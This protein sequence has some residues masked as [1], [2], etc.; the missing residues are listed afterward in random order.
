MSVD[1]LR[2]TI[3]GIRLTMRPGL[4]LR[5]TLIAV[6][7]ADMIDV[8]LC[9]PA[10]HIT[11][12]PI[13]TS[14]APIKTSTRTPITSTQGSL[15]STHGSLVS[16]LASTEA[17]LVSTLASTQGS[18]AST[19]ASLTSTQSSLASTLASTQGSLTST[20]GSLTSTQGSLASPQSLLTSTQSSLASTQSSLAS[21]QGSPASTQ[22]SLA[23]TLASTQGTLASTQSSLTPTRSPLAST[24]SS[25][26]STQG[27]I[28]STLA[29][30]Q[31]S[32]TPTQSPLASTE[33]TQRPPTAPYTEAASTLSPETPIPST[34]HHIP[35]TSNPQE[36]QTPTTTHRSPLPSFLPSS[37]RQLPVIEE[38]AGFGD[39]TQAMMQLSTTQPHEEMS[40]E[41]SYR[42]EESN[43]LLK[44]DGSSKVTTPSIIQTLTTVSSSGRAFATLP[45]TLLSS[46]A[47]LATLP[48]MS[49]FT[50]LSPTLPSAEPS[51]TGVPTGV[52]T[53]PPNTPPQRYALYPR[54]LAGDPTTYSL[55]ESPD[56]ELPFATLLPQA[57]TLPSVEEE[58]KQTDIPPDKLHPSTL[59][60]TDMTTPPHAAQKQ[61]ST[62]LPAI[63]V[64]TLLEESPVALSQTEASVATAAPLQTHP[65]GAS[66]TRVT[67]SSTTPATPSYTETPTVPVL[68]TSSAPSTPPYTE[69]PTAPDAP[70]ITQPTLTP[71]QVSTSIPQEDFPTQPTPTVNA[72]HAEEL[73]EKYGY[74]DCIPPGSE[75]NTRLHR[76]LLYRREDPE[77][78]NGHRYTPLDF[79]L[80]SLVNPRLPTD[81]K[82]YYRKKINDYVLSSPQDVGERTPLV[83]LK[84]IEP[85]LKSYWYSRRKGLQQIL[86][87]RGRGA[88]RAVVV[89][90]PAK[91]GYQYLPVCSK[92]QIQGA[93]D[94][95]QAAYHVG[96][97]GTLDPPTLE[98]LSRP[99]CGNPD[100][101]ME[102]DSEDVESSPVWPPNIVSFLHRR[103]RSLVVPER[104]KTDGGTD[105]QARHKD[106]TFDDQNSMVGKPLGGTANQ[107]DPSTEPVPDQKRLQRVALTLREAARAKHPSVVQ[108][109]EWEPHPQEAPLRRRRWVQDLVDRIHS[110]EEDARLAALTPHILAHSSQ[111]PNKE[112]PQLSR[113][114]RSAFTHLGQQFIQDMITWRL[115]T[116]G[117]SSQLAVSVQ[118]AALALAF[119]MWSEVIPKIFIEDNISN[120]INDVNINIGFGR[121]SHL[122]C[123]TEFDGLGGELSHA[124][125]DARD[126]Q[127]H[128][129]DDEHFTLDS[130]HGTNLLKV[131]VHEIGHVLGLGHV[132]RNYSIM[133]AVYEKVLP[134]QGLE[135][136]WEDRKLVQKIYGRCVG[137]FS[138]VFDFLR[139]RP[140][141]SLFYNTFFF[142]SNHFWMYENKY[143]RTRFGDP[144]YIDT[145]W[146][147]LPDDV[148]AYTHI[149][150]NTRDTHLFFKGQT[151]PRCASLFM[152]DICSLFGLFLGRRRMG[153]QLPLQTSMPN[154]TLRAVL[155]S[156]KRAIAV[157]LEF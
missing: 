56:D 50:T 99:R 95:F 126:A 74:L 35:S 111:A 141:G 62:M 17:S 86:T 27:S 115:V 15:E 128:M 120:N 69:S 63:P 89:E 78:T 60:P 21:T 130:D 44:T 18:S 52:P 79:R 58:T 156:D 90:D 13:L 113:R 31:G 151:S 45:F 138:T 53:E 124:L 34:S 3:T 135:L 61:T 46:V 147:G 70:L 98:L 48:T 12:Q 40:T 28:A 71:L 85:T 97:G 103:R 152:G 57:T 154:L 122:G 20:Q 116:T 129:D 127:I 36:A 131:A 112:E 1:N 77:P 149:F 25:L 93:I 51:T 109:E 76:L 55:P 41:T 2:D 142:R 87:G 106:S 91:L 133:Y 137:K 88:R 84:I 144:L 23:S 140:D 107:Y 5:L 148:D 11:H 33:H 8:A 14:P 157:V 67:P 81:M 119:R 64:T 30:T 24:Q 59:P 73:L 125:R 29:P 4:V 38:R 68:K 134:N 37:L 82:Q 75:R 96:V 117:Y 155:K 146:Q 65:T 16:T 42:A 139:W 105:E 121:R 47:G 10:N 54:L 153:V 101:L 102:E 110:G 108:H 19:Q 145:E 104:G 7:L 43:V 132:L 143:N 80:F 9:S 114:K 118:R 22:S 72:I 49:V 26:T 136:G 39:A 66:A 100:N 94:K 150:T 83:R 92:E 6:A 32:P 123:V